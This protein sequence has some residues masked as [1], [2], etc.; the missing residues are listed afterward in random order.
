[1]STGFSLD[2]VIANTNTTRN[3]IISEQHDKSKI[4]I[5]GDLAQQSAIASRPA[6]FDEREYG[7]SRARAV[8]LSQTEEG[9]AELRQRAL[10]RA[11]LA[12]TADGKVAMM[13]VGVA[14]WH[15]L[16]VVI[17][18]AANRTEALQFAGLSGWD[19]RKVEQYIDWNG[20]KIAT[21]TFAI[22]RGDTGSVLTR[23]K[24][25]GERYHILSNEECFDFMDTVTAC[26]ATYETAGALGDGERVWMLAH[27]PND[28]KIAGV[29]TLQNYVMF[30]T[31]HD[32][33]AST[34]VYPCS[35]RVECA[36][37]L[38]QSFSE[39]SNG[40]YFR[41]TKNQKDKAAVVKRMLGLVSEKQERF[42]DT[43][44]TLAKV[45][46][47]SSE[48]TLYFKGC[49][50]DIVNVTVANTRVTRESFND[51]SL[52]SAIAELTQAEQEAANKQ[53]ER[54]TKQRKEILTDILERHESSRCNGIP[55][56][57]GTAWSA[58]NAVTEFADHSPINRYKGSDI[59]RKESRFTSIME[60]KSAEIK[61]VALE[62]ILALAN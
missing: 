7:V 14:P 61:E 23:G 10:A 36:N 3:R 34:R 26:G 8:Q 6:G 54:V 60:G 38:R 58:Y 22:V 24:S 28:A 41:H 48:S 27:M 62:R 56:I 5:S 13:S 31:T 18:N 35:L 15:G 47:T 17:A 39:Q 16:G 46:L 59:A 55:E 30:T 52:L 37:T 9:R 50:D 42:A 53:L 44:N 25:V 51:K 4:D 12:T 20:E 29:D 40:M 43:A 19:M 21:G 33:S 45:Q 1:M 57:C 49:L 11:N 32:G 2:D